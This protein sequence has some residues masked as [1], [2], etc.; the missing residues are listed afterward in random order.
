M[1]FSIVSSR[2]FRRA[3]VIAAAVC[4]AAAGTGITAAPENP[5]F[6]ATV[7]HVTHN[8]TTASG[9]YQFLGTEM[10]TYTDL[11]DDISRLSSRYSGVTT[12]SI[13]TTADGRSIYSLTIGNPSASKKILVVGAMHGREYIT[14]PLLM[15]QAKDLLDRKAEG[16]TVLDNVSVEFIPMLNPDGVCISQYGI[17]GLQNSSM[18][19]KVTDIITS[20]A[21]WGLLTDQNKYTWYLNKWK[22]NANGVD[23]NRNFDMP[24]WSTLDDLR[25]K[26]A[27]DLYKG[28]SAESEAETKAI[29]NLVNQGGF[30]EVVNYHAQ[31]QCIYWSNTGLSDE[32]LARDQILGKIAQIDTGYKMVGGETTEQETAAQDATAQETTTQGT[33]AQDTAEQDG[34][35]FKD[36]LDVKKGIPNITLEVGLGTSPVPETQIEEIWQQ[37]QNVLPDLISELLGTYQFPAEETGG[38]STSGS[39]SASGTTSDSAVIGTSAPS[40]GSGAAEVGGAPE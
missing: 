4:I 38:D 13:G 29:V 20:W 32:V 31:G 33:T 23:I 37:N 10:Y 12:G 8:N 24:G 16:E 7:T 2:R 28:P 30:T 22:N 40:S 26:P 35:S 3:A 34:C 14:T 25:N 15:R 39:G 21:D 17:D 1:K 6:A 27:S 9:T 36:W 18:K 19:Q 5:A 11:K